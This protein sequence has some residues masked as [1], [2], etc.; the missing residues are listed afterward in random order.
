M[1]TD[2]L[3]AVTDLSTKN[4]QGGILREKNVFLIGKTVTK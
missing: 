1:G 4:K 3:S 2:V